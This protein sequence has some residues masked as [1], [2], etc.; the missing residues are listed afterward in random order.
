[1]L[2][3]SLHEKFYQQGTDDQTNFFAAPTAIEYHR[4]IGFG[5]LYNN[6]DELLGYARKKLCTGKCYKK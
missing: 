5:A 2:T 6:A 1:M 4:S 3:G